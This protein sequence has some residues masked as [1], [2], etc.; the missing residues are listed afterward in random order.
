MKIIDDSIKDT[1]LEETNL[2]NFRNTIS[3]FVKFFL[4]NKVR[5]NEENKLVFKE[6][7]KEMEGIVFNIV[8][9]MYRILLNHLDYEEIKNSGLTANQFDESLLRIPFFLNNLG[10]LK[11]ETIKKIYDA[12]EK[13]QNSTQTSAQTHNS[14]LEEN[15]KDILKELKNGKNH[16]DGD[17]EEEKIL[18]F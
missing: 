18:D 5:L 2:K 16:I 4:A 3:N 12:Y 1:K 10:L 15:L 6:N 9:N 13:I 17:I 11:N 14:S 7:F 8:N